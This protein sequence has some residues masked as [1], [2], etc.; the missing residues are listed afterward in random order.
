LIPLIVICIA[1]TLSPLPEK[2]LWYEFEKD[3][4]PAAV[5]AGLRQ[6]APPIPG[7]WHNV[8]AKMVFVFEQVVFKGN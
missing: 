5:T 6:T 2:L 3:R 7:S 4:R 8:Q 1:A